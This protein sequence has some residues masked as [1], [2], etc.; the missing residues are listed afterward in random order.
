MNEYIFQ[1]AAVGLLVGYIVGRLDFIVFLFK[2]GRLDVPVVEAGPAAKSGGLF[3]KPAR[4]DRILSPLAG[5]EIDTSTFVGAINT[6]DLT[7]SSETSLG[8]T[9]VAQDDI[10]V[11]VSKLARLKGT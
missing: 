11:S 7:K 2:R 3:A 5:V 8:K 6:D 4:E 9:S 10:G 1:G